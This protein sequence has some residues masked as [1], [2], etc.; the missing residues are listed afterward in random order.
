[1]EDIDV[2]MEAV[3]VELA[4]GAVD[5][6]GWQTYDPQKMADAVDE[7]GWQNWEGGE[8]APSRGKVLGH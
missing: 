8:L 7:E 2:D 6:D 1:M 4:Q 3:E 5:E